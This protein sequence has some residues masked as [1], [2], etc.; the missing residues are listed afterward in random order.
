MNIGI[1]G[2]GFVGQAIN[3]Y[4]KKIED[5][6]IYIYDINN[7][8]TI[9]IVFS[10]D[11]IYICLPTNYSE[12]LKTYD[13]V[14]VDT[15]LEILSK[16]Y[17][18]IIMIKSTI[19]PSYCA[20]M[21]SKYENLYII[22]NPEFLSAKTA[23]EDFAN[24]SHIVIGYT[25]QSYHSIDLIEKF[26]NTIFPLASISIVTSEESALIKLAANSFYATKIQYFTELYLL[27]EKLNISYDTI[28][29]AILK[30]NWINPMH[31]TIPGHDQMLSFGGACLPKD[32]SSLNQLMIKYN[33]ANKVINS[34]I[35][36][37][38]E[39]RE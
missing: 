5:I 17:N 15:T 24:Q 19:L 35:N 25:K 29:N 4:L 37:R 13:M 39:M 22:H 9:D 12:E 18:G 34:V 30:N 14:H 27:C 8:N 16:Y 3:N 10:S 28:K 2:F 20:E 38:N 23:N 32:I 11:I 31:T 26:Y 33:C 7:I 36:E 6:N 21:N 1:I